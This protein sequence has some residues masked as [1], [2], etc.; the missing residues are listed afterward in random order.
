[1][2]FITLVLIYDA[3]ISLVSVADVFMCMLCPSGRDLFGAEPFDP[4]ICGG[5]DFPPDVQSRLDEMQ[6]TACL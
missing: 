3:Y 4:F 1:M 6:V 2:S 5:A